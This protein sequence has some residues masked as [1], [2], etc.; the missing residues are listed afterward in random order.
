MA[1]LQMTDAQK[2]ELIGLIHE[3]S[4][5][6]DWHESTDPDH[7]HLGVKVIQNIVKTCGPALADKF[8]G[9]MLQHM[10]NKYSKAGVLKI[11]ERL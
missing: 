7:A 4:D 10:A 1:T 5:R 9:E 3:G 11:L 6:F 8:A 2:N